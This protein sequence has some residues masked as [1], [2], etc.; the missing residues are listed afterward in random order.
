ITR[1]RDRQLRAEERTRV[2]QAAAAENFTLATDAVRD[3]LTM[4]F[5]QIL[6]GRPDMLELQKRVLQSAVKYSQKLVDRR[7]D[8]PAHRDELAQAYNALGAVQA[9]L[10]DF[11][12]AHAALSESLRIRRAL[13]AEDPTDARRQYAVASVLNNIGDSYR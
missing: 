10:G 5:A 8:D 1:A 12:N 4:P 13:L 9:G 3:V 7:A 11:A 6:A 2:E